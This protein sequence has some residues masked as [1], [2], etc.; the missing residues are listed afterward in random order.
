MAVIK[1]AYL[2][3][4]EIAK[5]YLPMSRKK[6]RELVIKNLPYRKIGGRIYVARDAKCVVSHYK[7]F[8]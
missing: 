5:E 1:R 4:E 3:I 2:S 8:Q 7:G 6:I